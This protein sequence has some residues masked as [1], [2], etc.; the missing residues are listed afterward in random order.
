M[1]SIDIFYQGEGIG[2]IEHLE[3]GHDDTFI[4]VKARLTEKH[5]LDG[6]TLIFLEDSDEPLGENVLVRERAGDAG[7]KAHLHRCR[8]VEVAVTFNGET[9]DRRFGPGATIARVKRWAAE[10]KFGMTKDEAG[11]HVLQIVGTHDRPSGA[12][13]IG[14]LTTGT[15]C[16]L[17]LDLV[18][19][20]R[21]NGACEA[22]A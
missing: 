15:T 22:A 20:E 19:N 13:H 9:V 2:K 21:I 8:H 16:R 7:V 18:P 17:S 12:V 6:A 4:A 5:G 3:V 10:E 11:E 14:T 1:K